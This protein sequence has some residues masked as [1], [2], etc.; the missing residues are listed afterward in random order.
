MRCVLSANKKDQTTMEQDLYDSLVI[1][2]EE[3]T[4]LNASNLQEEQNAIKCVTGTSKLTC[5]QLL[6]L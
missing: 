3:T 4:S 2:K 6:V 5:R 1:H